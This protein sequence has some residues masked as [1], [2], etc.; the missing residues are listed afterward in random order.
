MW[1]IHC[2]CLQGWQDTVEN[3][4][5]PIIFFLNFPSHSIYDPR[6]SLEPVREG[7]EVVPKKGARIIWTNDNEYLLLTS[8]TKESQRLISVY[9]S[10]DLKKV[11]QV[12]IKVVFKN[13]TF[14]YTLVC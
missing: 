4:F 7:G 6:K 10:Q 14:V 9:T 5:V 11:T 1:P 3:I 2:H 12:N 13:D 8:F